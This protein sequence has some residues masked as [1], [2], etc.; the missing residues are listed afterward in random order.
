MIC[1]I[2]HK[3]EIVIKIAYKAYNTPVVGNLLLV[4]Y[5]TEKY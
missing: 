2:I 3:E 1:D 5:I 4:Y